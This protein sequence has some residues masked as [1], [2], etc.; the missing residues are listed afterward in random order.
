[1]WKVRKSNKFDM[2]ASLCICDLR[3]L[4]ADRP[5]LTFESKLGTNIWMP[6]VLTSEGT[7][8]V[9]YG[10]YLSKYWGVPK[11]PSHPPPPPPSSVVG[12]EWHKD[13]CYIFF[14]SRTHVGLLVLLLCFL[15]WDVFSWRQRI[16][17][18]SVKF[19]PKGLG[20]GGG[21]W[22]GGWGGSYLKK[23]KIFHFNG[24]KIGSYG[25]RRF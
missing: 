8:A 22:G 1:M 23:G 16:S 10:S 12:N 25:V 6:L 21:K 18:G 24:E 20:G 3:N 15:Q 7:V 14:L 11:P 17:S 4:F 2:S 9:Q 13:D 5:P 19:Q